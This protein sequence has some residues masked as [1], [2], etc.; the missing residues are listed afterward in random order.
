MVVA[1]F[2]KNAVD[3]KGN[4]AVNYIGDGTESKSVSNVLLNTSVDVTVGRIV[5][6]AGKKLKNETDSK[7]LKN[8]IS[9]KASSYKNLNKANNV[10]KNGNQRSKALLPNQAIKNVNSADKTLQ[11]TK[12]LNSIG[13]GTDLNATHCR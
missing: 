8:A 13:I 4:G 2:T 9:D 10:V 1:E 7:D 11:A 12:T 6:N 5:P 3:I